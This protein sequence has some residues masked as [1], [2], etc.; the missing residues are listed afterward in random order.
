MLS[1]WALFDAAVGFPLCFPNPPPMIERFARYEPDN[2]RILQWNVVSQS[3]RLELTPEILLGKRVEYTD[4][5]PRMVD[6]ETGQG[7]NLISVTTEKPAPVTGKRKRAPGVEGA[8]GGAG[9]KETET[10]PKRRKMP[11]PACDLT[12]GHATTATG[13]ERGDAPGKAAASKKRKQPP[14]EA[15]EGGDGVGLEVEAAESST[16][17]KRRKLAPEPALEG[18]EGVVPFAESAQPVETGETST[19]CRAAPKGASREPAAAQP[20]RTSTRV[21][22]PSLAA[23]EAAESAKAAKGT[24]VVGRYKPATR[25]KSEPVLVEGKGRPPKRERERPKKAKVPATVVNSG[26]EI[27]R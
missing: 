20:T 16:A 8:E 23:L 27:G 3:V 1:D 22:K 5:G 4:G 26:G 11:S 7:V 21:K 2:R 10:G 25:V 19:K 9:E 24:E 18:G 12:G 13:T 14:V 15:L 6:L 17:A